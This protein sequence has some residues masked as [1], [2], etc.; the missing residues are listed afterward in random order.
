M[1][2]TIILPALLQLFAGDGGGGAGDGGGVAGSFGASASGQADSS[3]GEQTQ[4]LY[5]RQDVSTDGSDAGSN[6]NPNAD[7]DKKDGKET[8]KERQN[9]Y[10]EL[11]NGEFKDLYQQDTQRMIDRRFKETKGLQEQIDGQRAILDQ[12]SGRY[13]TAPGDL[14]A[15]QRAIDGDSAMWEQAAEEAG[16][17]VDQYRMVE[18]MR[19]REESA[20]RQMMQMQAAMK[21]R[22]QVEAWTK[23]AEEL[24]QVYPDFNLQ[25]FVSDPQNVEYLKHH[26]PMRMV[27]EYANRDAIMQDTVA[28]A[29]KNMADNIRAKGNRPKENGAAQKPGVIVKDNV[30][31]LTNDD[32]DEI[33]RRVARGEVISF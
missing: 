22:A 23:E 32:I 6:N 26:V 16:M 4:V 15:L 27:Y 20:Q 17:T 5:G 24:K 14:A 12:L 8:Q 2:K 33:M 10:R 31:N 3:G 13:G 7:S 30:E 18:R 1:V 19:Q 29:Q 28:N 11:I 9:R 21:S 25:E